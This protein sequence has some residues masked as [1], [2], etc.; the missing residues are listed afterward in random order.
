MINIQQL[1]SALIAA[2]NAGDTESAQVIANEIKNFISTQQPQKS[3]YAD[4][5]AM[6]V[7]G[8]ALGNIEPDV[9]QLAKQTYQAV[10]SPL[11]TT[12][13]MIDLA[14]AGMSKVLD[15]TGLGK[16]ANPQQMEK[17]RQA[18]GIIGQELQDVF[19]KE[20]LKQRIAE[21]PITSLLDI[22]MLG[23]GVT[24]PLKATQ[25]G[26]LLNKSFKAIDPTQVVTKPAGLAYE[27]ISDV[28]KVKASQYAPELEKI[29]SY[30]K[31]GFIIPPS[32]VKGTKAI[33][34]GLEYFLGE[35]TPSLASAK[36]QQV[37]NSKIRTFLDVPKETPLNNAMQVIKDRTQPIYDEVAKIKPILVSKS[38]T[39]PQTRT[40]SMG[41]VINI[42][43]KK[44]AAQKTR[45]GQQI[46]TDIEKQR[47]STS[48]LYRKANNKAN[49]EN[50]SPDYE[51]AE[52]SLTKQQKLESELERLADLSGNK[53][54][55]AKLKE[56]RTDR[57]R[58]HSIENAIDKGDLNANLFAKQNK[59]RYV[60]GE[61]KE[62]ID[63]ANDFPKLVKQQ[64]KQ[65]LLPQSFPEL[66]QKIPLIAAGTGATM[67]GG[68]PAVGALLAARQITPPL[69]L[70]KKIQAG[71]GTSNFM[72]TGS[73][74]LKSLT[75]QPAV[76]G[77]TYI[78]SLLQSSDIGLANY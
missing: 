75:N 73:G 43:S 38:Q 48:E 21:K 35:K 66:M 5:S 36:N 70:S 2:D 24:A 61:G 50:K 72:P 56:A 32:E 62:I 60:T 18:R 14:S 7:A 58:G 77:A 42:P 40:G 8:E 46:L 27:K 57:A 55:A 59:K 52:Q 44:V 17:Y 64:S 34:R 51:K 69:L 3:K 31:A 16:Y 19:T 28:A 33:Q 68:L 1:E 49:L 23:Q 74:L 45:S 11:Q 53:D 78:P 4:M 25:L 20:G 71:L 67:V 9:K 26:G 39:I 15:V 29:Q 63:F 54:L 13:G 47:A 76:T 22:S 41:E 65:S 37:V 6:D 10:T 30:V 12:T